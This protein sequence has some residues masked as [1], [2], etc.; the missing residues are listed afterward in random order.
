MKPR[1]V[2]DL[3]S[4]LCRGDVSAFHTL[5]EAEHDIIPALIEQFTNADDGQCRAKIVEV[6]WH[7]RLPS[8]VSFLASALN[9]E[10]PGVW[11]QA[12]DGLVTIGGPQ[13][14]DALN[15]CL[16]RTRPDN[17][18]SHWIAEAIDQIRS[19]TM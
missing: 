10:H 3:V 19:Q 6:I 8:T 15:D 5:I 7:Y 12:L 2:C 1:D 13:S 9:D 16:A 11:K 14:L 4:A 17:D 18:R